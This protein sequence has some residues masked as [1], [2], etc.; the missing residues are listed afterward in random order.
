VF[1]CTL[2]RYAWQDFDDFAHPIN[3]D[4]DRVEHHRNGFQLEF[5]QQQ[6]NHSSLEWKGECESKHED[7]SRHGHDERV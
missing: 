6:S 1:V 5:P 7:N 4:S 3:D 2:I